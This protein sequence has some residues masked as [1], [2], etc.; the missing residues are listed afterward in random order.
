MIDF[1]ARY[2]SSFW[3]IL[4]LPFRVIWRG[5]VK[6][7]PARDCTVMNIANGNVDTYQQSTFWRFAKFCF[8]ITMCIWAG[9]ATYV[10]IYHRPLLQKRTQ[11]LEQM[12]EKHDRQLNDLKTYLK[13]YN[14][15]ARD[16]NVVDDKILKSDAKKLSA[17]DKE[18]LINS[19]SKTIGEL[20]F[21][22]TRISEMMGTE[23]YAPE[24]D[25]LSEMSLQLE[26]VRNENASIKI[27]QQKILDATNEIADADRQIVEIVTK[28]T[29]DNISELQTN[30]KRVSANIIKLGLNEQKLIDAANKYSSNLIGKAYNPI[31][32]NK[33]SDPR[34]K[35]IAQ[36]IE[37]WHG[38]KRLT[39]ILPLGTPIENPRITSNFGTR[40]DPFTGKNKQHKG[41]DFAGKIGT[42]LYA[43][44][45][46]RVI[47][48]GDRVGYGT[49]VEIDHGLGFTTLYAHLSKIMVSRGDWIRPGTVVGL[50]GSSGRST[51]PHLHYEIRYKGTP[52]NPTNF[53]KE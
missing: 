29:T 28:L 48:A 49:T 1:I 52:F 13:K 41:I 50:G 3:E 44:A 8:T 26:L 7:F 6:I 37:K 10:Y 27:Q 51:G 53:I 19:K 17:K 16:L 46:G 33:N 15:L 14:D 11:Q 42:E 5:I 47:S 38:L 2:F 36:E 9:W 12:R 40:K 35:K 25:K 20:D 18:D 34:Y 22:H 21:L 4:T 30:I 32:L 45:P 31:Q 39:T 24:F 23:E 43:V